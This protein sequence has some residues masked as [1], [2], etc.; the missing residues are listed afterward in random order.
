MR[1]EIYLRL[2]FAP[3]EKQVQR[4]VSN[5]ISFTEIGANILPQKL[6]KLPLSPARR[7]HFQHPPKKLQ[8]HIRV[9]FYSVKNLIILDDDKGET[10]ANED[11]S[12]EISSNE[13]SIFPKRLRSIETLWP[14]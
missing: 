3:L 14:N 1:T 10:E 12:V 6:S 13:A 4:T 5:F 11:N 2:A 7:L 8:I 9:V